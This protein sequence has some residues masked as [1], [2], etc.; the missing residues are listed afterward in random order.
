MTHGGAATLRGPVLL[1]N[2]VMATEECERGMI[3]RGHPNA[4]RGNLKLPPPPAWVYGWVDG[5]F[6]RAGGGGA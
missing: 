5:G 3:I 2:F 4:I 6:R 1:C